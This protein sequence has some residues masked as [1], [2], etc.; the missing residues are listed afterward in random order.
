MKFY[1]VHPK[2]YTKLR[3]IA[4][5]IDYGICVVLCY[6][7]ISCIGSEDESGVTKVEGLAALPVFAGW[8]LYFVVIEAYNQATP[9]HD[10]CKLI[11]VKTS[12]ERISLLDAFKRR[13]LDIVD[14]GMYGIP[15]LICVS[16][17]AKHQRLGDLYADTLVV[18]KTD[19]SE[20]EVLF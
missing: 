10:I 18:K 8:F 19:I 9:G 1:N 17:T 20:K 15:A 13:I 7:Y 3:I 14:L 5:L 6:V 4:T 2:P 16:K 11:V 12:G